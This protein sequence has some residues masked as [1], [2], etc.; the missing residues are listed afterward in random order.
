M[1]LTKDK[2]PAPKKVKVIGSIDDDKAVEQKEQERNTAV[3]AA[4]FTW[5]G[6]ELHPFAIDREGDWLMYRTAVGKPPLG[7]VFADPLAFMSDAIAIVWF[8]SVEPREW[9]GVS[10]LDVDAKIR[11]WA[12]ENVASGEQDKIIQLAFDI[13]NRAHMTQAAI[14]PSSNSPGK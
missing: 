5:R 9:I 8:C 6:K 10:P 11:A 4:P 7:S 13:F 2:L 14:K 12:V 1:K 3:Q